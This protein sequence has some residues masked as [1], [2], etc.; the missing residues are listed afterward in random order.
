TTGETGGLVGLALGEDRLNVLHGA[1]GG[2]PAFDAQFQLVDLQPDLLG[3]LR[4][5]AR[6]PRRQGV[7]EL[8]V[9]PQ[10]KRVGGGG[11]VFLLRRRLVGDGRR[12]WQRQWLAGAVHCGRDWGRG[13][14]SRLRSTEDGLPGLGTGEIGRRRLQR[15][16]TV[17]PAAGEQ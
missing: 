16:R 15:G 2:G 6:F 8:A 12:R 9:G 11:L 7:G 10:A 1:I 3:V 17:L 4:R 5:P 13:S 14:R